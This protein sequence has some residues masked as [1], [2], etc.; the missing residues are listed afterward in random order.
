MV[1]APQVTWEI[2]PE[3]PRNERD[4]SQKNG[5]KAIKKREKILVDLKYRHWVDP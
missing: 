1:K 4:N 3:F 5:G 2:G